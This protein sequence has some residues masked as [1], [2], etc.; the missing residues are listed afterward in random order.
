LFE[1]YE[2]CKTRNHINS[3][4]SKVLSD[5]E[6][7]GVSVNDVQT[8]SQLGQVKEQI[9][10]ND[11]ARVI[12]GKYLLICNSCLWCASYFDSELTYAKCPGCNKGKVECMSI[13]VE[14][15]NSYSFNHSDNR[16]VE[17]IYSNN[18]RS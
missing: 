7:I 8:T 18:I 13:S 5:D 12:K 1:G 3:L 11:C 6:R 4:G 16:G 14:Q 10:I 15:R 17:L 9:N 2:D